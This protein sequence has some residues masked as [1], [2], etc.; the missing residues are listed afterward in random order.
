MT[1]TCSISVDSFLNDDDNEIAFII[2][3]VGCAYAESL[4]VN[5]S[6]L[7]LEVPDSMAME[8]GVSQLEAEAEGLDAGVACERL[9]RFL[10]NRHVLT[11]N[12]RSEDAIR[13][14]FTRTDS[15]MSFTLVCQNQLRM[16]S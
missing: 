10:G 3:L 4:M 2:Q 12:Q 14:L 5:P 1:G 15:D 7:G 16:A 6:S 11:K 9:N 13:A 8:L